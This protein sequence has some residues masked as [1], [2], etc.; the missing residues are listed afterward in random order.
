MALFL[1]RLSLCDPTAL[2]FFFRNAGQVRF[3]VEDRRAV[4]HIYSAHVQLVAVTM[5]QFNHSESDGIGTTRRACREYPMWT[6]INRRRA[7]EFIAF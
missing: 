5:Q 7:K 2:K 3:D 4:Q 1:A 6:I